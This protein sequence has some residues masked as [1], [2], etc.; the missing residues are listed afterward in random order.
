MNN[1]T[2]NKNTKLKVAF[3]AGAAADAG[4]V[5]R[6]FDSLA[7]FINMHLAAGV[8]KENIALALVVHGRASFD[9][10]YNA[11]YQKA[12]QIDN[13]SKTLIAV[14]LASNLMW[15]N[16]SSLRNFFFSIN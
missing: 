16:S 8:A 13:A 10:S 14:L 6:R 3:D 15:S 5:N 4:K 1:A 7:R 9:L 2:I 11:T 12:H